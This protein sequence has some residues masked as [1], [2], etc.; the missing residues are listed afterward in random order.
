MCVT[1]LI[2]KWGINRLIVL[3]GGKAS[4][5]QVSGY[6]VSADQVSVDQVSYATNGH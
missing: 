5:D 6:H 2:Y 4:A 1:T 3:A